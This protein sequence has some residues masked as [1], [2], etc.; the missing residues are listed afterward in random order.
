LLISLKEC[1][2]V[3]GILIGFSAGYAFNSIPY[4][5]R[6]IYIVAL[7]PSIAVS[8][9][10]FFIPPSPRWLAL[11]AIKNSPSLTPSST[12][13]SSQQLERAHD[14]LC[15][16]R[17]LTREQTQ[18]EFNVVVDSLRQQLQTPFEWRNF[19]QQR[20]LW[21]GLII[22]CGLVSLQQVWRCH[23]HTIIV[24][25]AVAVVDACS[26]WHTVHRS[27]ECFVLCFECVHCCWSCFW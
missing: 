6:L 16:L 9:G 19:L 22:G 18:Y 25:T 20:V 27:T 12:D 3:L 1:F 5:W 10:A 23:K 17:Q 14:A 11:K 13:A 7:P 8:I 26:M 2:V 24:A 4:G 21:R 15:D